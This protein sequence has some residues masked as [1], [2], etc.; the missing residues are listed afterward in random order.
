[1]GRYT[2]VDHTADAGL[3]IEALSFRDLLQTAARGMFHLICPQCV[4]AA[5]EKQDIHVCGDDTAELLVNW[6]SELNYLFQVHQYLFAEVVHFEWTAG[7]LSAQVAGE[8]INPLRHAIHTEI[9]AITYHKIM[10]QQES[11]GKWRALL[12]FDL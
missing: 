9:K 3:E 7:S 1:M 5:Q 2:I 10:A 8:T 11:P 12:F 4:I 6:L